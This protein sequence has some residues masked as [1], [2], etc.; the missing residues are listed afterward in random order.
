MKSEQP[1]AEPTVSCP[2]CGARAAWR[3]NPQRPFCSLAC[4][5]IDLGRW[6]DERYRVAG[7][8]LPDELPPDDRSPQRAE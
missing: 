2:A 6:L 4:R 8:P 1:G 7:D 5:L 3:G